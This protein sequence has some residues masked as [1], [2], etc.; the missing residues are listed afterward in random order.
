M[1]FSHKIS[2]AFSFLLNYIFL[3]I[4]VDSC[5]KDSILKLQVHMQSLKNIKKRRNIQIILELEIVEQE[6]VSFE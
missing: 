5:C 4:H 1:T 3:S 6:Y 2:P